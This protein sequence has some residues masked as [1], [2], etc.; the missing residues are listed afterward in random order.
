MTETDE[1]S[2]PLANRECLI[3]IA[4]SVDRPEAAVAFVYG[5]AV[6]SMP[7]TRPELCDR[8]AHN[9]VAAFGK[10]AQEQLLKWSIEPKDAEAIVVACQQAGLVDSLLGE[11]PVPPT[12]RLIRTPDKWQTQWSVASILIV[13]TVVAIGCAVLTSHRAPVVVG[14]LFVEALGIGFAYKSLRWQTSGWLTGLLFGVFLIAVGGC[15]LFF[16]LLFATADW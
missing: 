13:T 5:A 16:A 1:T 14:S 4:Q 8:I 9:A 6:S 11:S 2:R 7:T 15:G 3:R 12:F 10:G